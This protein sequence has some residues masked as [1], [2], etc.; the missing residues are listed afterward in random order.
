MASKVN[1]L[2]E[3]D[4]TGT[5]ASGT[6]THFMSFSMANKFMSITVPDDNSSAFRHR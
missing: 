3:A 5:P 4:D 1:P 2:P 6:Q